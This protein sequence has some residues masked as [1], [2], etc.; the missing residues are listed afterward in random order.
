MRYR[1]ENTICLQSFIIIIYYRYIHTYIFYTIFC[2]SLETEL[3]NFIRF[4]EI[5]RHFKPLKC[6]TIWNVV[7]PYMSYHFKNYHYCCH[8]LSRITVIV[9]FASYNFYINVKYMLWPFLLVFFHFL[10]KKRILFCGFEFSGLLCNTLWDDVVFSSFFLIFL[11]KKKIKL[12]NS[13]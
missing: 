2:T 3:S 5:R 8:L 4:N 7:S 10:Y 13:Y 6:T 12:A 11:Y 1:N 9:I